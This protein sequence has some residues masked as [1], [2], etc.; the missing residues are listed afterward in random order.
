ML[1]VTNATALPS[2]KHTYQNPPSGT[3]TK[4]TA[5]HP[6]EAADELVQGLSIEQQ[7]RVF[8]RLLRQLRRHYGEASA[9]PLYT[10]DGE[11]LGHVL[12]P[13]WPVTYPPNPGPE[14]TDERR[15]ELQNRRQQ[16]DQSV[17]LEEGMAELIR[18]VTELPHSSP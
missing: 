18:R 4:A 16:L 6:D 7:E 1:P 2:V 8:V 5:L 3:E 15:Q 17:P 12:P 13:G 14:L 9:I 10:E 11:H